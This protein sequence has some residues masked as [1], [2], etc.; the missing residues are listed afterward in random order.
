MK[1]YIKNS[2]CISSLG[3]QQNENSFELETISQEDPKKRYV[4]EP[5]YK[6]FLSFNVIR[7]SAR[8]VKV[9][10]FTALKCMQNIE[11]TLGG[12]IVGT[13]VGSFSYTEKF[14]DEMN[15]KNEEKLSPNLFLQSMNSLLSGYI[16]ILTKCTGYNLTYVNRGISFESA[17]LDAQAQFLE[18]RSRYLLVGAA[19]EI[20][21][22]YVDI[23]HKTGYLNSSE[24]NTLPA[25]GEGAAFMLL[26][27][28]GRKGDIGIAAIRLFFEATPEDIN[29]GIEEVLEEANC[30][31]RDVDLLLTTR[32][33]QQFL[34]VGEKI[35]CLFYKDYIGEY[36]TATSFA[37]WLAEKIVATK[38][39]PEIFGKRF[40][41]KKEFRNILIVNQYKKN[42]SILLVSK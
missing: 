12:I 7:R 26:S 3:I 19:D 24:K 39:V 33:I 30:T 42:A 17:L 28:E 34:T 8:Y 16:S 21:D 27:A 23:V 35:S 10:L 18:D 4:I 36:P 1:L 20:T 31:Y 32:E 40:G 37:V 9:G 29:T 25:L 5:D 22:N 2:A 38:H 6:E 41:T 13:G 11:H 14:L 15:A